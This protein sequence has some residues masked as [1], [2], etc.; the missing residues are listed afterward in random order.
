MAPGLN[1]TMAESRDLVAVDAVFREP[2]CGTNS[3]LS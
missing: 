3:L 1:E 2:F